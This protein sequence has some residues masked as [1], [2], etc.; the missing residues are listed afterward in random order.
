MSSIFNFTKNHIEYFARTQIRPTFSR[1]YNRRRK[2]ETFRNFTPKGEVGPQG[3]TLFPRVEV[4][5]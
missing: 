3:L 2:L 1:V 4:I 5:P